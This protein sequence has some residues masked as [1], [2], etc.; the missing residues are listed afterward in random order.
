MRQKDIHQATGAILS[1]FI[2]LHYLEQVSH[3]PIFKH[4][5]KRSLNNSIKELQKVEKQYFDKVGEIDSNEIADKLSANQMAFISMLLKGKIYHEFTTI[6]E[7]VMAYELEPKAI[8][9]ISD[10]ILIKNNATLIKG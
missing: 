10:K 3:L 9:G 6:Q 4:S 8:K 5:L 1:S 7:I 2:A